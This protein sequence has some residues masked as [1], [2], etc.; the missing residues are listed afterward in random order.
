MQETK[1]QQI[2][3]IISQFIHRLH[4]T[5]GNAISHVTVTVHGELQHFV[6]DRR[7][8]HFSVTKMDGVAEL[9]YQ[10]MELEAPITNMITIIAT[11]K[12]PRQQ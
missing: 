7:I 9:S 6:P 11:E 12:K 3:S 8:S 5:S 4:E 10:D 1:H 2:R